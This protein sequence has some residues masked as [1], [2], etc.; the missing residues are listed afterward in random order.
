MAENK[1]IGIGLNDGVEDIIYGLGGGGSIEEWKDYVKYEISDLFGEDTPEEVK[2]TIKKYAPNGIE[3]VDVCAPAFEMQ[4]FDEEDLD[5]G[6]SLI[7]DMLLYKY[8]QQPKEVKEGIYKGK[9]FLGGYMMIFKSSYMTMS[10]EV[11]LKQF[12]IELEDCYVCSTANGLTIG[13]FAPT[14]MICKVNGEWYWLY[15]D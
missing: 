8:K 12:G 5:F 1:V 10:V 7:E 6:D 13:T 11:N 14:L 15:R 9:G 4:L 3:I 2:E